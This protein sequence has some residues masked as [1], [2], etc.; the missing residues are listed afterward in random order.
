MGNGGLENGNG[1]RWRRLG[2]PWMGQ[3]NGITQQGIG[4]RMVENKDQGTLG[5]FQF[6]QQWGNDS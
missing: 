1:M 4:V 5:R 3:G 2:L 6:S